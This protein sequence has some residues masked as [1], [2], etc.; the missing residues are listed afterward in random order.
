MESKYKVV[1]KIGQGSYGAAFIAHV[2]ADP[3]SQVVIKRISLVGMTHADIDE[4]VKEAQV[5]SLLDH[6]CII[7]HIEHFQV[8]FC[9]F[10]DFRI[11]EAKA[12]LKA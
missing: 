6:P 12:Q 4:S 7:R 2:R 10:F 3:S 8:L 9:L 11:V 5:L 1:Q